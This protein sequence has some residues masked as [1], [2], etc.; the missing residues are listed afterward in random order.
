[1]EESSHKG[2]Q[3]WGRVGVEESGGRVGV[4]ESGSGQ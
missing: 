1:M 2:V 3:G 4:E